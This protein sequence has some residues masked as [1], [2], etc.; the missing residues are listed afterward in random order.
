[1]YYLPAGSGMECTCQM[2]ELWGNRYGPQGS[3]LIA[4][5][6]NLMIDQYD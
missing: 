1:M 3:Q 6:A 4:F 5:K 2:D